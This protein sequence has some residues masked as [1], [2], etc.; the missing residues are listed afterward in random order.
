[1][2]PFRCAW[3]ARVNNASYSLRQRFSGVDPNNPNITFYLRITVS[4]RYTQE[5]PKEINRG[6]GWIS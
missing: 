3:N 5:I 2:L 4:M 1:M 6:E